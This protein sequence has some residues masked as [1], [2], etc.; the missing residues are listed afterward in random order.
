MQHAYV[1]T[2][3]LNI[4]HIGDVNYS[5]EVSHI[6]CSVVVQMCRNVSVSRQLLSY[7]QI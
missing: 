5:L 3:V 4:R 6:L 7:V 2:G 1:G